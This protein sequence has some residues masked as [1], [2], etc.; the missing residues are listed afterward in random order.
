LADGEQA[1][2][3]EGMGGSDRG[4]REHLLAESSQQLLDQSFHQKIVYSGPGEHGGTPCLRCPRLRVGAAP[5]RTVD[6]RERP[7][8]PIP[9]PGSRGP[10]FK[11]AWQHLDAARNAEAST[12]IMRGDPEPMRKMLDALVRGRHLTT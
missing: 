4:E 2:R 12:A 3:A 9:G 8:L 5:R 6:Q 10:G 11:L 7:R 1:S